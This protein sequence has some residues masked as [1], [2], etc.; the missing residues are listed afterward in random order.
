MR[1]T[2]WPGELPLV[3]WQAKFGDYPDMNIHTKATLEKVNK[4]TCYGIIK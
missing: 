4:R 3:I 2:G 1:L